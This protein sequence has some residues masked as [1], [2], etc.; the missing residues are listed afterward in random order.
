[1][2]KTPVDRL[3]ARLELINKGQI[4]ARLPIEG[5]SE[6]LSS[7]AIAV[8]SVV[9]RLSGNLS[10]LRRLSWDRKAMVDAMT[11]I[12]V[13]VDEGDVVTFVNHG[14]EESLDLPSGAVVGRPVTELAPEIGPH[15]G[16]L[17]RAGQIRDVELALIRA[18]GKH[19][20]M[21]VN[22]SVVG[23]GRAVVLVARDIADRIEAEVERARLVEELLTVQDRW[24]RQIARE[25]HDE[26]GQVLTSVSVGLKAME[27]TASD[28]RTRQQAKDMRLLA[29]Q[30]VDE[31]R[32]ITRGLHPMV[33]DEL[34]LVAALQ[35]YGGEILAAAGVEFDV[36][37]EGMDGEE[38]LEASLEAALFRALQ[39]AI[40][41]VVRHASATRASVVVHR[42]ADLIRCVVEDDGAG[43]AI[44][45]GRLLPA[46]KGLGLV[47]MRERLQML[48]GSVAFESEV[49]A[50]TTVY[51]E[52]PLP[53]AAGP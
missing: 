3:M 12:L 32:R 47:G 5:L 51:I 10:E 43:V 50:G 1:M 2:S 25:L 37:I 23:F 19:R 52:A 22:G 30:S 9:E 34:G 21:A 33:L 38:R 17:R 4:D 7:V 44:P 31:V 16:E 42:R 24:R 39:E 53:A 13:A 15:L 29:D 27:D 40:T 28:A 35:R 41:N 26:L 45:E 48:G 6:P 14:L 8:N 36:Q 49:G 20:M 11:D 46:G 18:D